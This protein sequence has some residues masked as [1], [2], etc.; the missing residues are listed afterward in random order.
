[1]T[2]SSSLEKVIMRSQ[3]ENGGLPEDLVVHISISMHVRDDFGKL[4]VMVVS[5]VAHHWVV[6]VGILDEVSE[7]GVDLGN[8]VLV[9]HEEETNVK[10]D[11]TVG[12]FWHSGEV[13]LGIK[14][15]SCKKIGSTYSNSSTPLVGHDS[16]VVSPFWSVDDEGSSWSRQKRSHGTLS[17]ASDIHRSRQNRSCERHSS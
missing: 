2:P 16:A 10:E 14:M 8:V 15:M 5:R 3:T 12:D 7:L 9:P 17:S 13:S 11:Q 1:M 6:K 4:G